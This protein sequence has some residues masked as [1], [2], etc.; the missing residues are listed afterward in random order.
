MTL[1]VLRIVLVVA[2]LGVAAVMATPKGRLPLA[3]RGLQKIIVRDSTG[4]P[5]SVAAAPPERQSAAKRFVAFLLVIVAV[6]VVV[7]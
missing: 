7:L 1:W 4:G 6:L 5:R 2:L 3:L